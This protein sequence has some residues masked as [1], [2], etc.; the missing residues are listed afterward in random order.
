MA[1][2]ASWL[3]SKIFWVFKRFWVSAFRNWRVVTINSVLSKEKQWAK[4][5]NK[6][7]IKKILNCLSSCPTK[8]EWLGNHWFMQNI[9]DYN[10]KDFTE[11]VEST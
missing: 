5:S 2:I 4:I 9:V 6:F 11:R 10:N 8:T 7:E 3:E 1:G